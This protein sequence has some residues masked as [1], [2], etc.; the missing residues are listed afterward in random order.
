MNSRNIDALDDECLIHFV[1]FGRQ[2]NGISQ[3]Q[4]RRVDKIQGHYKHNDG[5]WYRK[6]V[7]S[8]IWVKYPPQEIRSGS[9]RFDNE[10]TL[11]WT[12]WCRGHAQ[13]IK[14]TLLLEENGGTSRIIDQTLYYE[15]TS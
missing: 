7:N 9:K 10:R 12:F 6:N 15:S 5:L 14:R 1:T 4:K 3:K 2:I 8:D 11:A 13:S